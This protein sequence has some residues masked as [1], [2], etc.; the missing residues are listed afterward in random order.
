MKQVVFIAIIVFMLTTLW[1]EIH[2][3]NYS[4]SYSEATYSEI[5]GGTVLGF[6]DSD[7]QYIVNPSLPNGGPHV[8][9]EG[10]AIGFNFEF[11]GVVYD[12]VGVHVDGWIS[13]G[14]SQL[15]NG[16]VNMTTG[17]TTQP[18]SS[19]IP[20]FADADLV[21]RI[22]A[23][24]TNLVAQEGSEIMI[25]S[26][27]I[28]PNREFTV[29][30]KNFRKGAVSESLNFQIKLIESGMKVAVV[31]GQ[32]TV[33][34]TAALQLGIRSHPAN[35]ATNFANRYIPI[36]T[37][38]ANSQAGDNANRIAAITATQFPVSGATFTWS[39][40]A[41][42]NAD[43]SGNVV[44]GTAPLTVQFTDLSTASGSQISSWNWNFGTTT[45]TLQHP[46]IT[47]S[48]PGVY[49][50]SLT[51]SDGTNS[52]T[53]IKTGY[54]TVNPGNIPGVNTGITMDGFDAIVSWE[55][56]PTEDSEIPDYYYLYFNGSDDPEGEFYFLAPIAYP[57][58]QYRHQGVGM[59]AQ[60]MFYRVKAVR[61]GD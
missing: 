54:I 44:S 51:I 33:G 47:F 60:H 28:A 7:T 38:W 14:K 27:G 25:K 24:A 59:G 52:D 32:Q 56:M 1:G 11:G 13:L 16:A 37:A 58:T 20:G 45:S 49:D 30:W 39:P 50:V 12:R 18:L 8:M 55:Q 34:A 53:E 31:W 23:C 2:L 21:A 5:S 40:P 42:I 10:F 9:G 17:D 26:S 48:E 36:G 4:F 29:Q 43:F 46:Q 15:G 3:S 61:N 41:A 35:E 6:S 22:S 19:T 57:G